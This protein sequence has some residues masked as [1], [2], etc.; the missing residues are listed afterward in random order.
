MNGSVQTSVSRKKRP[1][2]VQLLGDYVC[3]GDERESLKQ[4][5]VLLGG[6]SPTPLKNDGVSN[7]WDDYS[8]P[9]CFWKIIIHSM[10]P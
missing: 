10:V 1:A 7:S 6:F 4:K 3:Q 8:I 5:Y 9:N 2:L